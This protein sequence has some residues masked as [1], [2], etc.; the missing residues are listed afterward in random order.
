MKYNKKLLNYS[1]G[2]VIFTS[3]VGTLWHF[4][5]EWSGNNKVVGLFTPVNEST[6]EHMK[7]AFFPMLIYMIFQAYSLKQEY[8]HILYAGFLSTIAA[9]IAIPVLFYGYTYLLGK[10][11]TPLDILTF[12]VSAVIGGIVNYFLAGKCKKTDCQI[13]S[14][15]LMVLFLTAFLLFTY[16]PPDYPIFTPPS[17]D[18]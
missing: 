3:I 2:A 15:L 14:V 4:F 17:A 10:N 12:Y 13:L 5:Y 6:W 16:N 18:L 8:P 7:L 9:T 11:Y 1:I